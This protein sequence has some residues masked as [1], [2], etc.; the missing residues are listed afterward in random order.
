M[1]PLYFLAKL[2]KKILLRLPLFVLY[3]LGVILGYLIYLDRR[4]RIHAFK[5]IKLAFPKKEAKE[6]KKVLFKSFIN[7]GISII[8]TFISSRLIS[9]L[10]IKGLER[11]DKQGGI[12]LGIHEGSWELYNL[13]LSQKVKYAI[14]VQRQ[15]R[16][17]L[18]SFLNELR[19]SQGLKV[20]FSLKGSVGY[21]KDNY[22]VG[23]AFDH[24]AEENALW[25]KFFGQLVPI[26]GGPL[27]LA[28]RFNKKIYPAF[29]WRRGFFRH[30]IEIGDP[31]SV[32]LFK[33]EEE[34]LESLNSFYQEK[35]LNHPEEYLWH[36]KRFKYK[37]NLTVVILDDKKT[38]HF[39]Q[40][41]ALFSFLKEE[42]PSVETIIIPIKY[43]F[44]IN[45]ILAEACAF[46]SG[47]YCLGCGACLR[48]LLAKESWE[49]LKG[50]YADMVI[51]AGSYL[52]PI[53]KL[54]SSFLGARAIVIFRPNIPLNR[55][56]L[57]ILPRH[58][59]INSNYAV[60]IKGALFSPLQLEENVQRCKE[61]F[62][63]GPEPK[64][65]L[66][67][68]GPIYDA[69][70]FLKNVYSFIEELKNFSLRNN[71]KLL[72]STS[73][74]TPLAV[75]EYLKKSLE[76]FSN[77]EVIVYANQE[78]YPFVFEG[79]A[80]LAQIVFVSSESISMVS[81][82]LSLNKP[83]VCVSLE[84]LDAKHKVFLQSIERE[85]NFLDK[86]YHIDHI[87]L[88]SS[89]IFEENKRIVKEAIQRLL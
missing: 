24:G 2:L 70:A 37:K 46:F 31:V 9:R 71:Y 29:G 33:K 12:F 81:E 40:S 21:L 20:C 38:G 39:K 80:Y 73:R 44:K 17:D 76:D 1:T 50:V 89:S 47:K 30:T 35:L 77:L 7:F 63:L 22:M 49:R 84:R 4:K 86:P 65:S 88:K 48:L 66:F 59:R 11:L 61:F 26:P 25:A 43:K 36:F 52:A 19:Q 64:I 10:E 41:E 83:C 78:N 82:V 72:I 68:G 13:G 16:R 32:N 85:V 42:R 75:E 51:S 8:E 27:F 28:K 45:R 3:I 58:D 5:N 55:F 62:S 15:K 60:K 67:L 87:E 79:F 56:D 6:I 34:V 18:D 74:R 57:V 53:N 14:F 69:Q 23:F 54:F